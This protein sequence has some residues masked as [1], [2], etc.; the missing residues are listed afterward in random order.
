MISPRTVPEGAGYVFESYP[1]LARDD[2]GTK[3]LL[4][5]PGSGML[6]EIKFFSLDRTFGLAVPGFRSLNL[7]AAE[8][9]LFGEYTVAGRVDEQKI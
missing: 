9:C 7:E 8:S 2:L 4:F 5:L 3:V 6:P 1:M